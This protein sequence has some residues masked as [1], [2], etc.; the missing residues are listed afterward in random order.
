MSQ[1]AMELRLRAAMV[2]CKLPHEA[3]PVLRKMMT[4]IRNEEQLLADHTKQL[5]E[6]G[7]T[8]PWLTQHKRA[9]H[10]AKANVSSLRAYLKW[11]GFEDD[12][13]AEVQRRIDRIQAGV[14]DELRR[15]QVPRESR[16]KRGAPG[17]RECH[18]LYGAAA[19]NALTNLRIKRS[20]AGKAVALCLPLPASGKRVPLTGRKLQR[21]VQKYEKENAASALELEKYVRRHRP[22]LEALAAGRA[23]PPALEGL[24]ADAARL[25][26]WARQRRPA[27]KAI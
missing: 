22:A 7:E 8:S 24:R 18:Y 15:F 27:T 9:L 3:E 1:T 5:K 4:A 10:T 23:A 20:V 6:L 16:S 25:L 11:F 12:P 19:L 2:N 21:R 14:Q 13:L 26:T 17:W